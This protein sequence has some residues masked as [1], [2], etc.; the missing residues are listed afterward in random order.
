MLMAAVRLY[1]G[2]EW[3]R[4]S[5][6]QAHTPPAHVILSLADAQRIGVGM[7]EAVQITSAAGTLEL[8]AQIDAGL[9]AGLALL[10]LVRGVAAPT[11]IDGGVT[12]VAV[13]KAE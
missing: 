1:S 4:G 3:A 6:L 10:P 7:G 9:A 8:P 11:I 12:R 13:S 5:K 2:G